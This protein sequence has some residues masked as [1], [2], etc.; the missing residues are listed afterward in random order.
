MGPILPLVLYTP[1]LPL[2]GMQRNPLEVTKFKSHWIVTSFLQLKL[3]YQEHSQPSHQP[4]G[5]RSCCFREV[6]E[7]QPIGEW[8]GHGPI[9]Q[10]LR[11]KSV[12]SS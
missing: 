3:E 7:G 8:W 10:P 5:K 11:V 6:M 12:P 1:F 9:E 4:P 2:H